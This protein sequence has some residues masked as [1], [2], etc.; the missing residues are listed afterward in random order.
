MHRQTVYKRYKIL[1]N[2]TL[3]NEWHD[4]YNF[5]SSFTETEPLTSLLLS[6]VNSCET[7]VFIRGK[8]KWKN[9]KL[10]IKGSYGIIAIR[11]E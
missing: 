8:W 2:W 1:C 11:S 6:L 3:W 4:K 9:S 5:I 10:K 7:W